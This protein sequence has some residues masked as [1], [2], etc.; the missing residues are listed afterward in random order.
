[1]DYLKLDIEGTEGAVLAECAHA[2]P[3][4][5]HLFIEYH[6]THHPERNSLPAILSILERAGFDYE[7]SKSHGYHLISEHRPMA[8]VGQSY[9]AILWA[10][11]RTWPP[12]ETA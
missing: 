12:A 11:N 7:V 3:Q 4:V 6:E 1:M 2:L 8:H 9:S 10:K 5:H